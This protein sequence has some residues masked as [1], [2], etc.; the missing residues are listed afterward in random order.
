MSMINTGCQAIPEIDETVIDSVDYVNC[1]DIDFTKP[2]RNEQSCCGK[3]QDGY[4]D[5]K[6]GVGVPKIIAP[7][8]RDWR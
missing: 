7:Y 8:N 6:N 1:G 5:W 2:I 3:L 4:Q